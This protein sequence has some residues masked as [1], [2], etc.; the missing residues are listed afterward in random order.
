MAK[1][2]KN[3]RKQ[4]QEEQVVKHKTNPKKF[5]K[6]VILLVLLI[7]LATGSVFIWKYCFATNTTQQENNS[8]AMKIDSCPIPRIINESKSA[9]AKPVDIA[10][11]TTLLIAEK[12]NDPLNLARVNLLCAKGLPHSKNID[13]EKCLDILKKMAAK[14]KSTTNQYLYKYKSAPKDYYDSEAYFKMLTLITVLQQDFGIKYNPDLISINPSIEELRK[15]FTND[16]RDVFLHGMLTGKNQGTCASMPVL[17]LIVGRMLGYPLKLVSSKAHLF[18]RWDDEH[19]TINLEATGRGLTIHPDNYYRK[20]PFVITPEEEK[21]KYFIQSM[22]PREE[23]AV[24]LESRAGILRAL[25][26]MQEV[27]YLYERILEINPKHPYARKYIANIESNDVLQ[28]MSAVSNY[29]AKI[30]KEQLQSLKLLPNVTRELN[31][32]ANQKIA[33]LEHKYKKI[34]SK[35]RNKRQILLKMKQ[36]EMN[37]IKN[38]SNLRL[39]ELSSWTTQ[40]NN[41]NGVAITESQIEMLMGR[42]KDYIEDTPEMLRIMRKQYERERR[43]KI[44]AAKNAARH[45]PL[46]IDQHQI[47]KLRKLHDE[48]IKITKRQITHAQN[49]RKIAE[50]N[51]QIKLDDLKNIKKVK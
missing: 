36:E 45:E 19:E 18:L 29:K 24:F 49:M 41:N 46:K 34:I 15:P 9:F 4:R 35:N 12:P 1:A 27:K 7:L 13:I 6:A 14:V 37:T 39:L 50:V 23:L 28:I 40:I 3:R 47:L 22:S 42:K 31:L 43:K 11:K 17:Y 38:I 5:S 2:K 8:Q 21:Y 25:G 20:F 26:K 10:R 44:K 51:L 48:K 30:R 16:S 32:K 33:Q